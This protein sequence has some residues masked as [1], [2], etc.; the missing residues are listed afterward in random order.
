MKFFRK[1]GDYYRPTLTGENS[2]MDEWTR[3]D[4]AATYETRIEHLLGG[5]GLNLDTLLDTSTVF[6]DGAADVLTGSA[7]LDWFWFNEP[8]DHD[9]ATDLKDEVFADDLAWIEM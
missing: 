2:M 1:I 4:A 5:G 6:S 7:G 8:D 3:A 9:R